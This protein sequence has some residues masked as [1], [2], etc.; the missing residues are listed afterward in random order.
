MTRET[1][2][3][4]VTIADDSDLRSL[5]ISLG[6]DRITTPTKAL[7]VRNF[8]RETN[9]PTELSGLNE[10]SLTFNAEALV[11][12][13]TVDAF[14]RR[15]NQEIHAL[16]QK[17][18]GSPSI[19]IPQFQA[20]EGVVRYPSATET[21]SLVT[22]AY[23]FSDLVPIPSIPNVARQ[24]TIDTAD[25]FMEYLYNC[26]VA[27]EVRNRKSILGY[28]PLRIPPFL[29][30]EVTEFYLEHDINAYYL[31]FD[32][33]KVTSFLTALSTI[34]RTLAEYG[35]DERSLLHFINASYG[36]AM[37]DRTVLPARDL[38]GFGFGLDSLGGVHVGA[39]RPKEYFEKIKAQ[40]NVQRNTNRL[41]NREDYG[42]YR[43]DLVA[44]GLPTSYPEDALISRDEVDGAVPSRCKRLVD[45]VNLQQQ[46]LEADQLRTVVQETPEETVAYF[47][48]KR[49]VPSEDL[50]Q[51]GQRTLM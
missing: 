34:K 33:A 5:E 39:R 16:V 40:K 51:M 18:A 14:A 47:R 10:I 32:G 19:A 2:I 49:Y 50:K 6:G 29:L 45:T 15:K 35:Y 26:Y 30:E 28:I 12:L 46:C 42:Y 22:V 25:P 37:N 11:K 21:A 41:L 36:K 20:G 8:Y 13:S 31:D 3:R 24:V 27:I 23:T 17:G 44:D 7:D 4:T 1:Q 9:F 43:F 38:I 48:S